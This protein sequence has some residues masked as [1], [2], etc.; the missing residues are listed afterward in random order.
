M[1]MKLFKINFFLIYLLY[2]IIM[3][4]FFFDAAATSLAFEIGEFKNSEFEIEI[5]EFGSDNIN[6]IK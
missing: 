6:A 5:I 1:D 4:Q 3:A 2:K